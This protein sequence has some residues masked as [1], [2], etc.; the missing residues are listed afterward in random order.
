[1]DK[2]NYIQSNTFYFQFCVVGDS[3]LIFM[4]QC[5]KDFVQLA[6]SFLMKV[7]TFITMRTLV[8]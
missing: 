3:C 5:F 1:M 8:F 4:S 6:A 7:I 2:N